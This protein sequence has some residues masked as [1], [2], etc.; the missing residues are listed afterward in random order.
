M[1]QVQEIPE[2]YHLDMPLH[3]R[4]IQKKRIYYEESENALYMYVHKKDTYS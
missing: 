1:K 4:D 2:N 3:W